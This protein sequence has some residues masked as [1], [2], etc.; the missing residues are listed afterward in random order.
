MC[1]RI[2]FFI[3]SLVVE[4]VRKREM[5]SGRNTHHMPKQAPQRNSEACVGVH[6]GI[7]N[8]NAILTPILFLFISRSRKTKN[9][10]I[11]RGQAKQIKSEK[12]TLNVR[13]NI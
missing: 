8:V 7:N 11:W 13:I 6:F 4:T 9:V 1:R 5:L 2:H 10:W 12:G 3:I